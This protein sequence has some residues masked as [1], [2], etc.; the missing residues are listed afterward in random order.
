MMGQM[1]GSPA[2]KGSLVLQSN[3]KQPKLAASLHQETLKQTNN[4]Q[5]KKKKSLPS[6]NPAEKAVKRKEKL[7]KLTEEQILE[8]EAVF[9]ESPES[10]LSGFPEAMKYRS[11]A[12][13]WGVDRL[14]PLTP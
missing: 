2:A 9:I 3:T 12:A 8:L 4:E 11:L 13:A 7:E 10:N 5:L 6:N 14:P 1:D